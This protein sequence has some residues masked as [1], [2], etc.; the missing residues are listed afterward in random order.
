LRDGMA[1]GPVLLR[2]GRSALDLAA[3]ELLP[4]VPPATLGGDETGDQ[5]LLPRLAAGLTA[6]HRVVFAAV[7]GRDAARALGMN[8]SGT[9]LLMQL[10]GCVDAVN[11]DGGASK[12]MLLEGRTLDLPT[13]EILAEEAPPRESPVRHVLT[14]ILAIPGG[15][16]SRS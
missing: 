16:G 8:L 3:E 10:L 13:T 11:L 6:D 1:G 12:R 7:D 5:S 4:G 2:E 9:G 14:G 15:E